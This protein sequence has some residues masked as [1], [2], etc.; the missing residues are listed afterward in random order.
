MI[1]SQKMQK[2]VNGKVRRV[3]FEPFAL[4]F[5]LH[6]DG[7]RGKRNIA[8]KPLV[9]GAVR[10]GSAASAYDESQGAVDLPSHS[11]LTFCQPT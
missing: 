3:V 6:G 2:S 8:E 5:C 11:N 1:I 9:S 7:F 4:E 10:G